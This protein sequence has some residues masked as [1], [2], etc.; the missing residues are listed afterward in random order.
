[1]IA[2]RDQR[3]DCMTAADPASIARRS[4]RR[5]GQDRL[6]VRCRQDH[7]RWRARP[8]GPVPP[9]RRWLRRALSIVELV[10]VLVILA[11]L[12]GAIAPRLSSLSQLAGRR[13]AQQVADVLSAA[14]ARAT[15][16]LQTVVVEYAE[17]DRQVI[18]RN[19]TASY[20]PQPGAPAGP[21]RPGETDQPAAD[22]LLVPPALLGDGMELRAVR[23]DGRELDAR[24]WRIVLSAAMAT[25]AVALE[26]A[27]PSGEGWLVQ[28]PAGGVR[29][30]LGRLDSAR[31]ADAAAPAGAIDLDAA[32]LGEVPW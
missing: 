4:R 23:V 21:P 29:A 9:K 13:T 12:A 3:R 7:G 5:H 30:A 10:V 27:G 20:W 22:D 2:Q 6:P 31:A 19:A 15:R 1:M 24:R 28:L 14:A 8:G 11:V 32:G 25:P 18:C 17:R 16:S 26:L